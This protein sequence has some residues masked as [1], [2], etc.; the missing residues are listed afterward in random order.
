MF[1]L[2][3]I[4]WAVHFLDVFSSKDYIYIYNAY[5]YVCIMCIYKYIIFIF[6]IF[7]LWED[8]DVLSV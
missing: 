6:L 7:I 3:L 4:P 1:Y 2:L 5:M 8:K